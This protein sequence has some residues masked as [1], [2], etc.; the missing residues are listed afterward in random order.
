M[1]TTE[2]EEEKKKEFRRRQKREQEARK[3][4]K[5][6]ENKAELTNKIRR[7]KKK[8]GEKKRKKKIKKKNEE[9]QRIRLC[10]RKAMS[11]RMWH[12]LAVEHLK[13]GI[14][15]IQRTPRP[16]LLL[17]VLVFY[18][19]RIAPRD[20]AFDSSCFTYST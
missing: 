4:K 20:A 1:P 18:V 5:K 7:G 11:Q 16:I 12:L 6:R 10:N 9:K 3:E 14:E 13:S 8:G 19:V 17:L 2:V 15:W